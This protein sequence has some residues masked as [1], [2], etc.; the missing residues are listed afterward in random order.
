MMKFM[1]VFFCAVL[2][3]LVHALEPTTTALNLNQYAQ[4]QFVSASAAYDQGN[5]SKDKPYHAIQEALS[6]LNNL[7]EKNK[8]AILVAAGFYAGP[9][10]H[11]PEFVDLYGGF[12]PHTWQRDL[13]QFPS[14]IQTDSGQRAFILQNHCTLDGFRISNHV[15]E[16]KGAA[17]YCNGVSPLITNNVFYNNIN[18]K[19]SD[20]NPV[21]WHETA[22]DGGAIYGENGASPLIKNNLF[23]QNKTENGRGA[24]AA[25]DGYCNPQIINNTFFQNHS[26]LDD[27]MRSSDGGALSLFRWCKGL[28]AGNVFLSNKADTKNDGG[29]IFLALWCSTVVKNNV[30]VNNESGDDAGALFVGG[31]EHRYDEPLDPYPDKDRFYVTIDNNLFIGN[32]NPSMNSGAMRFT[33]ES[34]GQFTNNIVAQNNGIYFQRS[35]TTIAD[36][37]ILDPILVIETKD[38][39]DKTII[40][41]NIIGGGIYLNETIAEVKNNYLRYPTPSGSESVEFVDNKQIMPPLKKDGLTLSV[42]SAYYLRDKHYTELIVQADRPYKKGELQ[43][44]V[45]NVNGQWSVIRTNDEY[46]FT[47]WGNFSAS[48]LL[49]ILPTYTLMNN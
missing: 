20:W 2:V 1:H 31:Q 6:R 44:R 3:P 46:S 37:I 27:P 14:V 22:N 43:N 30:F 25:F 17:I 7:D 39:L 12:N 11:L 36:N 15:Y 9:T 45:V 48:S 8:A 18:L 5:G 35:E 26:G 21:Y 28:I 19:P 4:V 34:R 13:S 49:T 38:Y 33:M 10:I 42:Y 47:L 40:K 41:N 32:R 23:I 24:A 16:G 29:A